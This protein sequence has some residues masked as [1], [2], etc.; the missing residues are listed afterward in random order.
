M[1]I[2]D[3]LEYRSRQEG[4]R[5]ALIFEGRT[6]TYAELRSRTQRLAHALSEIA[7][8]GDRV[9][10]YAENSA[11]Y[12]ECYYG[13]PT[14]G[15]ALVFVNYRLHP[16][17]VGRLLGDAEPTVV[18]TE[19]KYLDVV[20]DLRAS[21][22]SVRAVVAIGGSDREGVISYEDFLASPR[23]PYVPAEVSEDS[24]AWLLYTSGT[25]GMPKGAMLTH[26][27][28][29]TSIANA[30]FATKPNRGEVALF[31]MPLC[32]VSGYAI[33]L[34]H[35]T[36]CTLVL[37]RKYDP[38]TF[39]QH[40]SDYGVN[41]TALAPT[42]IN[43]LLDHPRLN[44]FDLSSLRTIVYGASA[45][46]L[47]VIRR[48]MARIPDI[49]FGTGFGMTELGGNVM[50]LDGAAHLA[51]AAA[52][53]HQALQSVGRE[54]PLTAVRVVDESMVDVIDGIGE[55]VVRGDQVMR[56][57]WRDEEKTKAAFSGPWFHTGDLGRWDDAGNLHIVDRKKDMIITGG[58]NVYPREVEEVL[59]Q[60]PSVAEAAVVGIP[61]PKWGETIVA[62][63]QPRPGQETDPQVIM[64]YCRD[65]LAGFK[66]PRAVVFYDELPKNT[67]GKLLKRELRE[68]LAEAKTAPA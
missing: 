52:G 61:D 37:M 33:L 57:Y 35:L 66:V 25:T 24:L 26:R 11:E 38:E 10:I 68:H 48:A 40:V 6:L 46:P 50:S 45:M 62:C 17:E 15:M 53:D 64:A 22:P 7:A 8:P 29:T 9:A 13:V 20:M 31:A 2:G 59:Y 67:T 58:E 43:M 28:M 34:R 55:I 12:V 60:H 65:H 27:N 49:Q 41:W 18:V 44:D 16:R 63:I 56:G 21:L 47:E 19:G 3:L 39:L 30:S 36:G 51:A 5:A 1:L 42:M 14:A 4:D 32:H 54:L 23:S